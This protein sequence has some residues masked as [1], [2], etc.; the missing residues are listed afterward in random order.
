M[1]VSIRARMGWSFYLQDGLGHGHV[2]SEFLSI[3]LISP[4]GSYRAMNLL[5]TSKDRSSL[6]ESIPKPALVQ[7][8]HKQ[9]C[10]SK[11]VYL[12]A[13]STDNYNA[14]TIIFNACILYIHWQNTS[15]KYSCNVETSFNVNCHETI[16]MNAV[17]VRFPEIKEFIMS[18]Q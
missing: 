16:E 8:V 11:N 4:I 2:G 13:V 18:G 3:F 9:I 7:K 6:D 15:S 10:T 12:K 17:I 14:N 5:N 1:Q